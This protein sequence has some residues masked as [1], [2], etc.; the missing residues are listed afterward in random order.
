MFAET[1]VAKK[2][3]ER[4]IAPPPVLDPLGKVNRSSRRLS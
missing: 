3:K 1:A 4:F 2:M